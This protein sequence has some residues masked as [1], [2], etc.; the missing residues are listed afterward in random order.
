MV[1]E[2]SFTQQLYGTWRLQE[3]SEL[4]RSAHG[5]IVVGYRLLA[6]LLVEDRYE[7]GSGFARAGLSAGHQIT[8]G[9]NNGYRILLHGRGIRVLS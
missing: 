4:S 6:D 7:E 5:D 8:L 3:C 1:C 9:Q 2:C